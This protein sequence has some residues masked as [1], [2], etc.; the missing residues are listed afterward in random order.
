[1][2]D[3]RRKGH[4][5]RSPSLRIMTDNK[6]L[7]CV[8]TVVVIMKKDGDANGCIVNTSG[9]VINIHFIYSLF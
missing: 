8:S 2:N 7:A 4:L 5:E 6:L 1:M 3:E 9:I